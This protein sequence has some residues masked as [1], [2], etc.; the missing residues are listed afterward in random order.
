[1]NIQEQKSANAYNQLEQ[2]ITFQKLQ[3]GQMVSEKYLME[4]LDM[5]RTPI[6]EALQHL[7]SERMVEIYPRR[8]I[9]IPLISVEV[10]LKLL[11]VRREVEA[12]VVKFAAMRATADQKQHLMQLVEALDNYDYSAEEPEKPFAEILKNIHQHLVIAA[13]NE[14]L[15]LAMAPLQGLSRRF[16]F[17]QKPTIEELKEGITCH[18]NILLAV[19]HTD[20]EKAIQASYQLNDH[21]T[22]MAY[23][24]IRIR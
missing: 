8:G 13:N 17:A 11:E 3:P 1:V 7:A 16:W 15:I 12:L 9:Q 19:C 24:H 6:R 18:K 20:T 23:R 21:L 22:N 2:M 4:L 10:Q 14:Y 5:G